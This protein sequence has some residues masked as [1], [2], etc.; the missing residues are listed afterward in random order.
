M[1][2]AVRFWVGIDEDFE[3]LFWEI[4]KEGTGRQEWLANY[5]LLRTYLRPGAAPN[6]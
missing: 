3:V 4:E 5:S 6:T 1:C 2:T